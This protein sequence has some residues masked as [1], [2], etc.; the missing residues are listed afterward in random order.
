MEG[1]KD[2]V[3]D[4]DIIVAELFEAISHPTRIQILKLL[5]EKPHGFAEIKH[6]LGIS[7]SGNIN[8]HLNKLSTLIDTDSHGDYLL[9]DQGSEALFMIES[10]RSA[11]KNDSYTTFIIIISTL[12]FYSS[13]ATYSLLIRKFDLSTL[14][15]GLILVIL[16]PL[17]YRFFKQ[18]FGG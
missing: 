7:S 14:L 4:R 9:T 5:E 17:V 15:F 2:D 11:K 1:D 10:T 6:E 18:Y 16:F 8:H 13:Y 12:I 3:L